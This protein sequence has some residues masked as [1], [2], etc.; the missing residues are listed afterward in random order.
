MIISE[1]DEVQ[2]E[3]GPFLKDEEVINPGGFITVA[4]KNCTLLR[5][6]ICNVRNLFKSYVDNDDH[7]YDC[8]SIL[9][10]FGLDK[11]TTF[12]DFAESG[13]QMAIMEDNLVRDNDRYGV[14]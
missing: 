11:N 9:L 5:H 3:M 12:F 1:E 4:V 13:I 14:K 6:I 2:I 10:D 7:T 8:D